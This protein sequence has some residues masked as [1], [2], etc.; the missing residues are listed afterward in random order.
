[1]RAIDMN[2]DE[3]KTCV[4]R[5]LTEIMAAKGLKAPQLADDTVLLGGALSIDSLDLAALVV[6]LTQISHKDPFAEGFIEFRT[7]GELVRLYAD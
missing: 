3:I 6:H 1:M 5:I 4:R 7:V 2:A